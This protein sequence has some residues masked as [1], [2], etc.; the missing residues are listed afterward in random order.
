MTWDNFAFALSE[1]V[2]RATVGG[3][4]GKGPHCHTKINRMIGER[5]L[6]QKNPDGIIL[7]PVLDLSLSTFNCMCF[8]SDYKIQSAHGVL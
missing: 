6:E 3:L 5:T 8:Y 2:G 4:R 7:I 1:E